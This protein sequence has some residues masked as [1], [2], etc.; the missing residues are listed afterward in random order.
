[1]NTSHSRLATRSD[2]EGLPFAW[3][4]SLLIVFLAFC[5]SCC[6][7]AA[8]F[9]FAGYEGSDED[10]A[11][12]Q[13]AELRVLSLQ[14]AQAA[15]EA[16]GGDAQAYAELRVLRDRMQSSVDGLIAGTGSHVQES[17]ARLATIWDPINQH[18]KDILDRQE[19]MLGLSETA[20]AFSA[21]VPQLQAQ[22]DEVVR[23][24]DE[25]G[26]SSTQ[27][28]TAVRQIV[29]A[30]RM[31]RYATEIMRG[32]A[33]A[34]PAADRFGRDATMFGQ[35]LSGLQEGN[36]EQSIARVDSPVARAILGQVS[37]LYTGVQ[38]D[39]ETILNASTELFEVREAADEIIIHS[40][41]FLDSARS[42]ETALAA[43]PPDGVW[44]AFWTAITACLLALLLLLGCL[45]V[46]SLRRKAPA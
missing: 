12:A 44:V 27:I 11:R 35:V 16:A 36:A 39:V 5:I 23:L 3:F 40:T 34:V 38:E 30:D 46:W 32:G 37:E 41:E 26:A 43:L 2:N 10:D 22:M 21:T 31:L 6:I 33:S 28:Y 24:M 14:M 7:A 17:L 1:M 42:L 9:Y 19:F 15:G 18:T 25:S 20:G 4:C 45:S 13:V 29:L 8:N